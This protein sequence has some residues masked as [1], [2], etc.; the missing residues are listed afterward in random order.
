MYINNAYRRYVGSN[1]DSILKVSTKQ[2]M[3]THLLKPSNLSI[4][5]KAYKMTL[6]ETGTM[7]PTRNTKSINNIY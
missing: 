2:I 5:T 6:V 1:E 3:L 7:L 4:T